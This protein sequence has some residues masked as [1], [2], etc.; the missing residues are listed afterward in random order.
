MSR[1]VPAN[2]P[3][4][5]FPRSV[6]IGAGLLMLASIALAVL[7]RIRHAT[8]IPAST[9]VV[10]RQLLFADMPNGDVRI[11]DAQTGKVVKII[12]GQAGFLRGTMRGLAQAREHDGAGPATPFRLTLWQDHR[13]TL[14]DPVTRR[15]IELEAF[16]P[17]NEAAFAALLPPQA[18]AHGENHEQTP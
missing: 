18:M 5:T 15:H 7:G 16:G 8:D 2:T 4:P 13:L 9:P 10:V 14:D 17:T 3:A 1:A 6:L 11:T 12:V